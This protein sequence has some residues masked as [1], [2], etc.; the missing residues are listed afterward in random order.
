MK[1]KLLKM[2]MVALVAGCTFNAAQAQWSLTGN[3]AAG[4]NFLGTTNN[5]SMRIKTNNVQRMI[6]DSLGK[7]GIGITGPT[8]LLTVQSS[9][10]VPSSKW[11]TSGAPV[12]VG[13]GEGAAGNADFNLLM[14]SSSAAN[15]RGVIGLKRSRGTLAAPTA[16]LNNDQMGSLLVSGYDG[17]AFQG[18]AAVDFFADGTPT[19]GSVPTRISFVT[20]TNSTTR[21]ERLKIGNTGD[22]T[23]NTNQFFLQK[24][25][26]NLGLGTITPAAKLD[27][28]GNVKI[29]D[30]TQGAGKVLTSDANGLASWTTPAS[31]SPWT[32]SGNDIFNNNSGNVGI[33]TTTPNARLQV[34]YAGTGNVDMANLDAASLSEGS[35]MSV[36]LGKNS[37]T[38]NRLELKY[39]FYK[40]SSRDSNNVSMA[41][42]GNS[43][44]IVMT[45]NGNVGIGTQNPI[46]KLD[47]RGKDNREG[48][49]LNLGNL[50]NTHRL[51]LFGGKQGD[52]NPF[53]GWRGGDPMRFASFR[54][55]FSEYARFDSIGRFGVGTQTPNGQFELSLDEG[56]KPGTN[57]WTVI[58]DA[59]LKNIEGNYSKGLKEIMQLKPITYHYKNVGSRKFD[60]KVIARQQIGFAAQD[61][62]KVFPEA[63][64]TDNDGYLNMNIHP[65]LIAQVN[66]IKEQ[67]SQINELKKE[68]I[69]L[70]AMLTANASK[71][72]DTKVVLAGTEAASI[73]QNAPNPFNVNTVIKYH[74]PKNSGNAVMNI[75]DAGGRLIKSIALAGNENGQ[76]TLSAGT[77]GTGSYFYSLLINGRKVATKEMQLA[78]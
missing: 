40:N 56:R 78:K 71:S 28:A 72:S 26:G 16:V 23:M 21:A 13:Y 65:I 11:I 4:T 7:V 57:T 76:V 18:A 74:L 8:Q 32:V 77:L 38:A 31:S 34:S 25:N 69:E 60:E 27:V 58:S 12:F 1:K 35:S 6:V 48:G 62:Q 20:G 33:G 66:A 44:T 53:I 42:S 17:T 61:V 68:I 19:T 63:V 75:T 45:G 10:S 52:P 49:V 46:S 51:T 43:N 54:N 37:D 59:R 3:A 5:I 39:N 22:I 14:G 9:G 70:K 67:Q 41:L 15:A 36:Y 47:V 24:S 64:G 2:G 30:G 50:D 29:A 73:E 55:G